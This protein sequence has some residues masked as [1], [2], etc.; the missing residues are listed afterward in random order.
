[1]SSTNKQ[2]GPI[3]YQ[4]LEVKNG[5]V[6]TIYIATD[7]TFS[8]LRII[9]NTSTNP[10]KIN[11]HIWADATIP[12]KID[13][14]PY[15]FVLDGEKNPNYHS[16]GVKNVIFNNGVL[17]YS[18]FE[19]NGKKY[20]A[21]SSDPANFQSMKIIGD[22]MYYLSEL[23]VSNID[24]YANS[25]QNS[26][27]ESPPTALP[28]GGRIGSVPITGKAVK[29]TGSTKQPTAGGTTD[30]IAEV[31]HGITVPTSRVDVAK[32][33]RYGWNAYLNSRLALMGAPSY[34]Y[35]SDNKPSK[36]STDQSDNQYSENLLQNF[37]QLNNFDDDPANIYKHDVT[38]GGTR[39]LGKSENL[40]YQ[41]TGQSSEGSDSSIGLNNKV[42][43]GIILGLGVIAVLYFIKK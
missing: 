20:I 12:L 17:H 33:A 35:R 34:I 29:Y 43:V 25:V 6:D 10:V 3:E 4:F 36:K 37:A 18:A 32:I 39:P 23:V 40:T 41:S 42:V 22:G 26:L 19:Y 38:H 16:H 21:V 1:M 31:Y 28:I 30:S 2:N 11:S 24:S 5:R 7:S 27:S 9:T 13:G 14:E 8:H 15:S